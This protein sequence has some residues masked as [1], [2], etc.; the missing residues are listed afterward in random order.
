MFYLFIT[1][2]TALLGQEIRLANQQFSGPPADPF[3]WMEQ[4]FA[5]HEEWSLGFPPV[6]LST[7]S[8]TPVSPS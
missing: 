7:L 1:D 8:A 5:I 3:L 4:T 6:A 2:C